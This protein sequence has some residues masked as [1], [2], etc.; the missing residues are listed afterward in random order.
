MTLPLYQTATALVE[1]FLPLW[2]YMRK[3]R[4]KED[5]KRI[6]ERYGYASKPRPKGAL[7]WIHAASVGEANSVLMFIQKLKETL[8]EL[9]IIIT[10][11][12][13][14]SARLLAPRL[15]KDVIH[16]YVPLDTAEYTLRFM[17]HWKPEIALFVES[18]LWPNLI[19][20]ANAYQCFMGIINGRMSE[21]SFAS[22]Q[23]RAAMIRKL[24]GCFNIV[25]AQSEEDKKRYKILGAKHADYIG[26]LKFDSGLL[27]CNEG[28]LLTLRNLINSRPVWLAA[29][30]HPGEEQLVAAA[31]AL[32]CVTRPNLLTIIVPRHP[33]RGESIAKE[34]SASG[35]V[36]LRSKQQI[37]SADTRFYIADTIGELGLFYR[38]SEIVFMGGSLVHH[39][40][41]NPLEAARL[42]CAIVSGAAVSN[43][44]DIY[45]D[46]QQ[47]GACVVIDAANELA[48]QIDT[49]L[50]N[51]EKRDVLGKNAKLFVGDRAGATEKLLGALMPLFALL[52]KR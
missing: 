38:L 27:P 18:E 14:T 11:G 24:M 25:F 6:R 4:G 49:L 19:L 2:L 13:V 30:T 32:L 28:D 5:A 29:S 41:Q 42:S 16:Q 46:M 10:T 20:T 22:W 7:L 1:P 23:K 50:N 40:G 37:I 34:L 21:R 31:H 39:G 17:R 26:N 52:G 15:P 12:T 35:K 47:E 3:L 45:H 33:Q 36:A 48:A 43:F 44:S 8:P 9:S 51:P